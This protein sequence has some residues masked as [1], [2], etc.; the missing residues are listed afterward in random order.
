MYIVHSKI[1]SFSKIDQREISPEGHSAEVYMKYT[2]AAIDN[3]RLM[4]DDILILGEVSLSNKKS[5]S[6]CG[7]PF[8]KA[9]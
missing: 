9:R 4:M 2:A 6:V 5:R 1:L 3:K 7:F 8:F